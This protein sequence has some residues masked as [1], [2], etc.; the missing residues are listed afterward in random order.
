MIA[1]EIGRPRFN[2]SLELEQTEEHRCVDKVPPL[3]SDVLLFPFFFLAA[4]SFAPSL[5]LSLD[6]FLFLS[7]LSSSLVLEIAK[8]EEVN[9][10]CT[11]DEEEEEEYIDE[12]ETTTSA[13][14]EKLFDDENR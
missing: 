9:T 4:R 3:Q 10:G 13:L 1:T 5:S 8:T 12:K 7:R 2:P 6:L 11:E 14:L